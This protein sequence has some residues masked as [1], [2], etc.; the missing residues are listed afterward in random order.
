MDRTTRSMTQLFNEHERTL[1]VKMKAQRENTAA[2]DALSRAQKN[3]QDAW[4]VLQSHWRNNP[5]TRE[6]NLGRWEKAAARAREARKTARVT[7]DRQ[8]TASSAEVE[9]R[10]EISKAR[11]QVLLED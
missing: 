6:A 3:E 2:Q 7:S 11:E 8:N 4:D 1:A 9:A 10:K 5:D